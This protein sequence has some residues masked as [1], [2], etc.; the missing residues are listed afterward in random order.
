M[1]KTRKPKPSI[2]REQLDRRLERLKEKSSPPPGSGW[3]RAIRE[4]LGMSSTQLA[5]RL[6]ITKQ[7]LGRIEKNEISGAV[8]IETLKRVANALDCDLHI[9]LVPRTSLHSIIEKRAL[10]VASKVVARTAIHMD[11][12]KQGTDASFQQKRVKELA[13]ELIRTGDHRLWEE[14]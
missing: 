4:S 8:T 3:I 7:S 10:E 9:A 6:G 11:L 13:D 14:L 2:Q 12:E 1:E 5:K